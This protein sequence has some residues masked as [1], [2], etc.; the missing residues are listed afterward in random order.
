MRV[1]A[2]VSK[3]AV[4]V[5]DKGVLG[6]LAWLDKARLGVALL[7]PGEHRLARKPRA[8]IANDHR[9]QAVSVT[10]LIKEAEHLLSRDG[11]GDKLS[12]HLTRVVFD[13]IFR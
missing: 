9:R 6:R 4:G 7:G 12:R 5:L 10:R 3:L 1:Q 2:F 8:V 13:H 11:S